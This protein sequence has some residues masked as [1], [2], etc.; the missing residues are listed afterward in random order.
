M[1]NFIEVLQEA[2]WEVNYSPMLTLLELVNLLIIQL[3]FF[4][5]NTKQLQMTKVYSVL[6]G[7]TGGFSAAVRNHRSIMSASVKIP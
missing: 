1:F 3:K 2:L 7:E 6:S 5:T 4:I